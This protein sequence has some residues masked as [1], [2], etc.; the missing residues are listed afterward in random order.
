[1][2][3]VGIIIRV[4]SIPALHGLV[5]WGWLSSWKWIAFIGKLSYPIYLMNLFGIGITKGLIIKYT[6]WGGLNFVWVFP[7]LVFGGTLFPIIVNRQVF[8]RIY[9]LDRITT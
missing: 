6:T 2:S 5:R 3:D 8:S 7:L 4:L 1:L 9:W